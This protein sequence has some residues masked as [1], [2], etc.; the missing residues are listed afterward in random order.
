MAKLSIVS[1]ACNK[2]FHRKDV[3]MILEYDG[4]TPKRAELLKLISEYLKAPEDRIAVVKTENLFGQRKLSIHCHIY[5][6]PEDMKKYERKYVLRRQGVEVS[7][8]AG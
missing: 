1:E 6:T 5:D 8:K 3:Q 7:G 2:M 4:A